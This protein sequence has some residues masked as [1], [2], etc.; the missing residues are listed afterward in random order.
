MEPTRVLRMLVNDRLRASR[1]ARAPRCKACGAKLT[2]GRR[3]SRCA[4]HGEP[5]QAPLRL[6]DRALRRAA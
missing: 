4:D 1:A 5:L 2:P 3:P 6:L